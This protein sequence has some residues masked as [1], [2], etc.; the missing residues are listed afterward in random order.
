MPPS[1]HLHAQSS[2][3]ESIDSSYSHRLYFDNRFLGVDILSTRH[4]SIPKGYRK[5]DKQREIFAVPRHE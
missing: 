5:M 3:P 4:L 2:S 1:Q